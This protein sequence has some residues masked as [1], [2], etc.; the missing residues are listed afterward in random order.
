MAGT[1]RA[2][3]KRTLCFITLSQHLLCR[4]K[5]VRIIRHIFNTTITQSSSAKPAHLLIQ[6]G[7]F[8]EGEQKKRAQRKLTNE[9]II[10]SDS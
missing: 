9:Q 5:Q 8:V 3:E 2:A 6:V 7:W 10:Q 1:L 4:V